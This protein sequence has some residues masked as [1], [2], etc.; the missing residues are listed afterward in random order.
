MSSQVCRDPVRNIKD[1][2]DSV[3]EGA[4]FS[5]QKGMEFN[6]FREIVGKNLVKVPSDGHCLLHVVGRYMG[7]RS[8]KLVAM[9]QV[10]IP[11]V[12]DKLKKFLLEKWETWLVDYTRCKK[13]SSDLVDIAPRFLAK[14]LGICL[15]IFC[16]NGNVMNRI[17]F[18]E[19][20][21][22]Y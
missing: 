9:L 10:F 11:K 1:A 2:K 8:S 18:N 21:K 6:L 20:L 16:K 17:R 19:Q 22:D 14:M 15:N 12:S 7:L 3:G 4:R 13:W 5:G